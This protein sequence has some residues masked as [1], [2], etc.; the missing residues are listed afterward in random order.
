MPCWHLPKLLL[1]RDGPG[2]KQTDPGKTKVLRVHKHLHR[3][4]VG[5]TQVVDEPGNVAKLA[6]I[7]AVRLT[8][9]C[10]S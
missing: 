10:V 6:R 2:R 7:N 8:I 4:E 5:L 9:L 3:Y 1:C